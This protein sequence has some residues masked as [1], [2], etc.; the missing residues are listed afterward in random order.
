MLSERNFTG[1]WAGLAAAML[2]VSAFIRIPMYP[3]PLTMQ[4]FVVFLIPLVFGSR[5]AFYGFAAYII[6]G[7]AGLPV[8]A[9]GGG[10]GYVLMPS[11]GY[12]I[13][14]LVSAIP[15][16]FVC[17]RIKGIRGFILSGVLSL[18]IIY[19]L[20]V[21]GLY[22]NINFIQGKEMSF[23][24]AFKTGALAFILPDAVKL[25]GAVSVAPALARFFSAVRNRMTGSC[26]ENVRL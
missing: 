21:L 20:G 7:L 26:P 15:A 1:I 24:T 19:A 2:A 10:I 9:G 13:G 18:I 3:V 11:F 4:M 5:I 25:A 17:S 16:G 14:Y 12:I 22:L 8:F 6:M 23:I